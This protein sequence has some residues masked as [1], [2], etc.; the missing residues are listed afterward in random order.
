MAGYRCLTLLH[1]TYEKLFVPVSPQ[2]GRWP[3]RSSAY[4]SLAAVCQHECTVHSR[5]SLW[6]SFPFDIRAVPLSC[7]QV[8]FLANEDPLVQIPWTAMLVA[9][10]TVPRIRFINV[11]IRILRS[12]AQFLCYSKSLLHALDMLYVQLNS[13]YYIQ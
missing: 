11:Q 2:S 12:T 8:T 5:P 6:N 3:L 1:H 9:L 4:K 7:A 13:G 10:L